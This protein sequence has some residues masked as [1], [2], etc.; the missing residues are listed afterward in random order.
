MRSVVKMMDGFLGTKRLVIGVLIIGFVL[1]WGISATSFA[2]DAGV[3]VLQTFQ[4]GDELTEAQVLEDQKGQHRILFVMGVL[5]LVGVLLTAGLGIAMAMFGKQVFVVHMV[6]AG[7][8]VFL[9]LAHA[10][11][12]MVW[13]FPF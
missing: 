13:F 9:S 7:F 1:S 3:G 5:L 11:T 2:E 6:S 4:Q 12:A 10:V 8:T